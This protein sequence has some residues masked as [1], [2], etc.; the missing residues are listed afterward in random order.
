MTTAGSAELGPR[1]RAAVNAWLHQAGCCCSILKTEEPKQS[2]A[3]GDAENGA[4]E[5][6]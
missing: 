3:H 6:R 4:G 2:Q 1:I 5:A